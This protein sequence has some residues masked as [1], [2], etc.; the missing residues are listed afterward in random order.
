[1]LLLSATHVKI[2]AAVLIH[3]RQDE[4][5][6]MTRAL[7]MDEMVGLRGVELTAHQ[8]FY[9]GFIS[10]GAELQGTSWPHDP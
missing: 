10:L 6:V 5:E 7:V 8:R 3:S 4:K 9:S 2:A 1:M